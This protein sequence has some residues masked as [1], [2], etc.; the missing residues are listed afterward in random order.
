MKLSQRLRAVEDKADGPFGASSAAGRGA[1]NRPEFNHSAQAP[2]SGMPGQ[3]VRG[4]VAPVAAP[5]AESA[6]QATPYSAGKAAGSGKTHASLKFAEHA[7]Q[8][9]AKVQQPV[10]AFAALKARAATALFER[11]GARFNDSALS[12]RRTGSAVR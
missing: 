8:G 10:D 3:P 12:E 2:D 7:D 1:H 6:L 4:A 11:L 9:K 5:F